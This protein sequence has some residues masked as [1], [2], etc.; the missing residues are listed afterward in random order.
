MAPGTLADPSAPETVVFRATVPSLGYATFHILGGTVPAVSPEEVPL[1][2]L[3]L[4][5]NAYEAILDATGN[6]ASLIARG[7][8]E[9]NVLRS[10]A[11]GNVLQ[12]LY[13]GQPDVYA[14]GLWGGA[15]E[16]AASTT[17][18]GASG[19]YVHRG[20]SLLGGPVL[21]RAVAEGE[22]IDT[23]VSK[24]A[25][26][27]RRDLRL[28]ESPGRI[29]C[30][31]WAHLDPDG[32]YYEIFADPAPPWDWGDHY[33]GDLLVSFPFDGTNTGV[34]VE[35]PYGHFER[36]DNN[37]GSI[38]HITNEMAVQNWIDYDFFGD[39]VYG[40]GLL[41]RG[42]PDQFYH[43]GELRIILHYAAGKHT[44]QG[45]GGTPGTGSTFNVPGA[46]EPGEHLFQYA[47][48]PHSGTWE[49]GNTWRAGWELNNP[50]T[51]V[52]GDPSAGDLPPNHSF[53]SGPES[54]MLTVLRRNGESFE[55]RLVEQEGNARTETV[56]LNLPDGITVSG[57]A[58]TNFLGDEKS[59]LSV[60]GASFEVDLD[61]QDIATVRM[62]I[63]GIPPA[64]T[65]TPLPEPP[66]PVEIVIHRWD[67]NVSENFEGWWTN[68]ANVENERV[69]GGV[70]S[71][72]AY[73]RDPYG[74][75]PII[76]LEPKDSHVVRVR[77]RSFFPD[78]NMQLYWHGPD[79][80][81]HLEVAGISADPA[82]HIYEFDVGE[83]VN[84]T[85]Q[86]RVR[87]IR[88]DP[89]ERVGPFEI[90]WIEIVEVYPPGA[91]RF[92]YL[93]TR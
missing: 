34:T 56:T 42:M 13:E 16:L 10:G 35:V 28:P 9:R 43:A 53:V 5:T 91:D 24:R 83:N 77:L 30:D 85:G 8:G 63:E 12:L 29:E 86:P 49:Q 70:L 69:S 82:F 22:F 50:L 59:A 61:P 45:G 41:N 89:G 76:D 54:A 55:A 2:S 26:L 37:N 27:V 64:P 44:H 1:P 88:V 78:G 46:L 3:S 71:G 93:M 79:D 90:D 52:T 75:G 14:H 19:E 38:T 65:P 23:R 58:A 74:Y 18:N 25:Y 60:T 32:D 87:R 66:D 73:T 40:A 62:R 20:L 51:V 92:G 36:P 7:N 72:M 15:V 68:W 80:V 17:Q 47:I 21:T 48:Y 57:C 4:E 33:P 67:F 81:H 84:W 31:T 39:G 11:A 6:L